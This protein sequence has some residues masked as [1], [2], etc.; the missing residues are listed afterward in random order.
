MHIKVQSIEEF[1]VA[2]QVKD[3]ALSLLWFRLLL[4]LWLL[5]WHGFSP[6]PQE[7]PHASGMVKKNNI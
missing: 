2:W 4:W 7:L 3:L 5:L 6:C 1:S